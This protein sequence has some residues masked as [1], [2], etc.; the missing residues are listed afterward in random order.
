VAD[1]AH[2]HVDLGQGDACVFSSRIIPGNE[3]PIRNLQNKLADRGVHD[4]GRDG[5]RTDHQAHAVIAAYQPGPATGTSA[6]LIVAGDTRAS[7][8]AAAATLA[9]RP[10]SI[11][12]AYAVALDGSGHVI[13]YGGRP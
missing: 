4:R 1:G 10:G 3:V 5:Q 13:A 12:G 6:E 2:P 8:C 7:A 11:R 9:E